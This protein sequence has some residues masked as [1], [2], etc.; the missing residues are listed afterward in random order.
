MWKSHTNQRREDPRKGD[1]KYRTSK[2]WERRSLIIVLAATVLVICPIIVKAGENAGPAETQPA[3]RPAESKDRNWLDYYSFSKGGFQ[4]Y[5]SD[6]AEDRVTFGGEIFGRYAYWNWFE[7]PSHDNEYSYGFQRTRLHLKYTSKYLTAF[8][9]PQYVHM[10][11]VPDD[12]LKAPPEGPL[13]MGGLYYVHNHDTEP[14]DC[15]VHQAYLTLHTPDRSWLLK[16]GRF[17]YSDGLEVLQQADGKHFNALKKTRLGDRMISPFGWS[18]FGRSFDGVLGQ[19]DRDKVNATASFFYPTQGGWEE[20]IDTT[21]DDIR[22]TT[23]TLT[24]KRG[25]IIPGME[26]AGFYYNYR[27]DRDVTQRVD[28]TGQMLA[29][30]GV[31]I[32]IHMI[33]GHAV[34]VYDVGPGK[35]DVLLWG[36]A[37]FG[38]WYELDQ[39]AYALSAEV[40]YQFTDVFAKPWLRAG[41][42]VGSG[43]SN[44]GDGEHETFFQMAPG[45]RKYNLLPYCDLM[46]TEDLFFQLITHPMKKLMLRVDYHILRLNEADDRWY[47]GS[48]PTQRHGRIFGYL[49]RPTC[50][51]DELAQE[52]DFMINYEINPHWSVMMSY[53]HIFGGDV[54]RGVY[55]EN[56]DADYVSVGMIFK[57]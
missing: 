14:Y 4:L 16:F 57:F 31:D 29:S 17:E 26:L 30:D 19:Y 53:S 13:G 55:G 20:D 21:I 24:G 48:G 45:T 32:D 46:N 18:A 44:P 34:G 1:C 37:Q 15:G 35:M 25:S 7:G 36:G 39:K 23:F 10:F 56:D 52:L 33:G 42:Y 9:Q 51:E 11:G 43:D 50:G 47:M 40:G 49:G 8:V 41:Y 54:V 27:D 22:I 6:K 3:E 2:Y 5:K 28:N 38:D 12:A